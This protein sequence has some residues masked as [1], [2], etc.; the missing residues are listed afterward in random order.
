MD[1]VLLVFAVITGVFIFLGV[2]QS[3]ITKQIEEERR[4]RGD[5]DLPGSNDSSMISGTNP[6]DLPPIHPQSGHDT[7]GHHGADGGLF[8]GDGGGSVSH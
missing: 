7:G 2:L 3:R 5:L 4:K 1:K 6:G 8:G